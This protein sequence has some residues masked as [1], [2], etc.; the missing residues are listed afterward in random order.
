MRR[1]GS[2][3][4]GQAGQHVGR[5][6]QQVFAQS[7]YLALREET[8]PLTRPLPFTCAMPLLS[9]SAESRSRTAAAA[10]SL[11]LVCTPRLRASASP[12]ACA[13]TSSARHDTTGFQQ[14]GAAGRAAP[15]GGSQNWL[16]HFHQGARPAIQVHATQLLMPIRAPSHLGQVVVEGRLRAAGGAHL[17]LPRGAGSVQ[18]ALI[19]RRFTGTGKWHTFAGEEASRTCEFSTAAATALMWQALCPGSKPRP[20]TIRHLVAFR[21][22]HLGPARGQQRGRHVLLLINEHGAKLLAA[23]LLQRVVDSEH[24][25]L[26]QGR[27]T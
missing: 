7:R 19:H 1:A 8:G 20:V 15:E 9:P 5:P 25:G 26:Q 16:G 14:D 22:T 13:Q 12:A 10:A 2:R 18:R 17:R 24:A 21:S 4:L 3:C 6:S 11:S 27:Q 23:R